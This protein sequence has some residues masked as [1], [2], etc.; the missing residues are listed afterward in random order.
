MY[1][2]CWYRC[3]RT[4]HLANLQRFI[5]LNCKYLN[6]KEDILLISKTPE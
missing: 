3:L 6:S 2:A 5:L 4:L 1:Q